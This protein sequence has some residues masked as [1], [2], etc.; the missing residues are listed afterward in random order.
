MIHGKQHELLSSEM[1][2]APPADECCYYGNRLYDYIVERVA[3]HSVKIV[4]CFLLD[5]WRKELSA[6]SH[7]DELTDSHDWLAY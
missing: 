1:L 7:I 3:T 4:V 6:L 2:V 5:R